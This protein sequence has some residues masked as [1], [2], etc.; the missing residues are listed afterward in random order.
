MKLWKKVFVIVFFLFVVFFSLGSYYIIHLVYNTSMETQKEA[1]IS[2]ACYVGDE[3]CAD[4]NSVASIN[5]LRDSN[6]QDCLWTYGNVLRKRD[7][8]LQ[9]EVKNVVKFD[10]NPALELGRLNWDKAE[11]THCLD[12]EQ[13]VLLFKRR[14]K[15]YVAVRQDFHGLLEDHVCVYVYSLENFKDQWNMVRKAI[16]VVASALIV[17]LGILLSVTLIRLTSPLKKLSEITKEV[18]AGERGKRV[19]FKGRDEVA[20]LAMNFNYMIEQIEESM[21]E[22]ERA[23]GEKQRFIDNLGHELRTPLTSISGYAEYLRMAQITEEDK[24]RALGYI[25]S[26]GHRLQKLSNT[27]LDLAVLREDEI[28]M[29]K[30]QVS[31]LLELM[32]IGFRLSFQ[33]KNLTLLTYQETEHIYGNFELICSLLVNLIENASRACQEGG[34]V[35]VRIYKENLESKRIT[36]SVEDNGIGI[37]KKDIEKVVEPFYRVDKARSR[38]MGGVGL[39]VTLCQQIVQAHNGTM[40]YESESGKGT[41]VT[42]VLNEFTS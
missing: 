31:D 12:T 24:Q 13:E 11:V 10:S 8:Y 26:E 23:A 16:P 7:V 15:E 36:L 42:V 18:A 25:I 2:E 19:Y 28:K 32:Q 22:L 34:T 21:E 6:L 38:E 27:L 17:A 40:Q 20:T 39:G 41:R 4:L 30:L 33:K 29:S 3:L 14:G 37:Q 9:Y 1:I 5:Q 35:T